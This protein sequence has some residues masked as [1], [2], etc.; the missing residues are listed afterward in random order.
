M[1]AADPAATRSRFDI[2]L[3]PRVHWIAERSG[4]PL[5]SVSMYRVVNVMKA[6][7]MMTGR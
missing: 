7:Q 4:A 5:G 3:G 1:E 6:P 2:R